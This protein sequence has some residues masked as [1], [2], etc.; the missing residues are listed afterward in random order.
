MELAQRMDVEA[1]FRFASD[2]TMGFFENR[3]L[4]KTL[5]QPWDAL[6][7]CSVRWDNLRPDLQDTI[8]AKARAG[9]G[10][11]IVKPLGVDGDLRQAI[12]AAVPT[13]VPSVFGATTETLPYLD[14]ARK[15]CGFREGRYGKGALAVADYPLGKQ[16]NWPERTCSL[17]P[18]HHG[19]IVRADS[20]PWWE[21]CY[22]TLAERLWRVAGRDEDAAIK[23]IEGGFRNRDTLRVAVPLVGRTDDYHLVGECVGPHGDVVARE[24][25][26]R[27]REWLE[28]TGPFV[29]GPHMIHVWAVDRKGHAADWAVYLCEAPGPDIAEIALDKAR[30]ERGDMVRGTVTTEATMLQDAVVRVE[31]VDSFGR[32]LSRSIHTLA[33]QVSF[34]LPTADVLSV[35]ARVRASLWTG[36][37]LEASRFRVIPV[38][39]DLPED[40]YLVGVWPSYYQIAC[41]RPWADTILRLQREMG[42]DF[43]L[44]AHSGAE[45]YHQVYAEHDMVPAA[46]SMHRVFFK[47][48]PQYEAMNLAD[49]AFM[50]QFRAAVRARAETAYRWGGFD[51][52]VGDENGYTRRYDD[53]TCDAFRGYL[54]A[55]FGGLEALNAQWGASF[56]EWSQVVPKRPEEVDKRVSVGPALEFDRFS[57]KLFLDAFRAADEEVRRIDPRNRIGVSGTREPGHYNGFDWWE[58]MKTLRHLAYYDGVQRE[59]I[60]S[61]KKPG[62]IVTSFVGY[63]FF[64]MDEVQTRFFLWQ[65][66]FSGFQGVSVYS[67]SSG[68]WHGYIRHDLNWTERAKWTMGE[69]AQLKSGIGRAIL[70]AKREP[71]RIAMHYSQR[72]LHTARMHHGDW[73]ANVTGLSETLKDMGLQYDFVAHEQVERG[74]LTERGYQAFI[75]PLALS[76]SD[77]EIAALERFVHGGGTLIV[78]GDAGVVN[79]NGRVREVGPL[80]ALAGVRTPVQACLLSAGEARRAVD[81]LG[82][83]SALAPCQLGLR[84]AGG[85]V[86]AQFGDAP[87]L[88]QQNAGAGRVWVLNALW[89]GYRDL[90]SSGVGGE[91][92]NR[93]SANENV[94]GSLRALMAGLLGD[95][96]LSAPAVVKR[97]GAPQAYIEQV[98]YRRGPLAYLCLLPRYFGGRGVSS[99][100]RRWLSDKDYRRVQIE[101]SAPG[102]VYDMRAG[103]ALGERGSIEARM[104]EGVAML[105]A[106]TPYEVTGLRLTGPEGVPRGG[107]AVFH[108]TVD[109]D[110]G[111]AGDH[112]V[113]V[114]LIG[115]DGAPSPC[116]GANLLTDAGEGEWTCRMALNEHPGQWKAV[117]RDTVSGRTAEF[118]FRVSGAP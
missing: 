73:L 48:A 15:G 12:D 44:M 61:F 53:V 45:R 104:A 117:A 88:V 72:S 14:W 115:P 58:L 112:V 63:D 59:C 47:N 2:A 19:Y 34:E 41:A 65:E 10:L 95:A 16:E 22:A 118:P 1:E 24:T 29:T 36:E 35:T 101:L 60:R 8:L 107:K 27:R 66:L 90:R 26:P 94:A 17:F 50:P 7:L 87:A 108:V 69:L 102:V 109:T 98:V 4:L 99:V 78:I 42:V 110:A 20:L 28:F 84:A 6:A 74:A 86:A 25:A 80:D 51:F 13:A 116:L 62:D 85:K 106:L 56:A 31:L 96:A 100:H 91:I 30:Y 77:E 32:I 83:R 9:M 57:D 70:T 37:R 75:L 71:A 38:A 11:M 111:K 5:Q 52:S 105:Y 92:V 97:N 64:D 49:P 43:A 89:T 81:I 33:K 18:P 67:A 93:T 46:E 82:V 21:A 113:N 40:D 54:E 3:R 39:H 114:Q 68:V 55:K 79:E 23:S 76:L 103:K